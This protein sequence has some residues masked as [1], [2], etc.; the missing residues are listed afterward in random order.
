[1]GRVLLLRTPCVPGP[2]VRQ[3]FR[4][5]CLGC[6]RF[7]NPCAWGVPG[8]QMEGQQHQHALCLQA[9]ECGMVKK[10]RAN[11]QIKQMFST[12]FNGLQQTRRDNKERQG[13]TTKKG[14]K[15]TTESRKRYVHLWFS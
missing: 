12:I 5:L 8:F 3:V 2:G 1:M 15:Q 9:D 14:S 6:A 4:S 10:K 13:G 11:H 7:S